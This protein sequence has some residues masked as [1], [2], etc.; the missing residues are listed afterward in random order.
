[1]TFSRRKFLASL[2][3][4]GLVIPGVYYAQREIR[5]RLINND[6]DVTAGEAVAEPASHQGDLLA[7]KLRGIWDFQL[8]D[9]GKLDAL[10]HD[11]L[12]MILDVGVTGRA[13]RGYLGTAISLRDKNEPE[14]RV[15]GS[16]ATLS[17]PRV[18][19]ILCDE[20]GPRYECDAVMDE[21]WD[22]WGNAG[23]GTLSGNLRDLGYSLQLPEQKK[24]FVA[25]KRLF[26][27]ARERKPLNAELLAWLSSVEHRLFHQIWH[28][29]RD[30]WHQ[31]SEKK[32]EALRGLGWQPGPIGRERDARGRAKHRNGSGEDFLFMH[33]G[34]MQRARELQPDLVCWSRLPLPA[35]FIEYDRQ[36]FI[37]YYENV[38]GCSVPPAWE[39]TEDEEYSQWLRSVKGSE[40][41]YSNYQVWESLYHDPEYLSQMTLGE[42][43]S[44][45]E[46]GI[47][48][49][50][51][52]RWAT[53]TRDPSNGM[54]LFWDRRYTDFSPRW[55]LPENDYLGDPFSSHVNPVF[56]M[57]H[58]WIDDRVE[59]WFRAHE[60][61]HPGEVERKTIKGVSWFAPG[62]WVQI[63]DPW[64]GA[65]SYGCIPSKNRRDRVALNKEEM[66][67]AL[68]IALSGETDVP[69][70]LRRI[71][72]RPWYA[73]NLKLE[74]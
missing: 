30:K 45:L 38:D 2:T 5:N 8:L 16:L 54:P 44:E 3:A 66:K 29:S 60:R 26:P 42:F 57:F 74:K 13:L 12:E 14:Y 43:G 11:K 47:H 73:R 62:R 21:I 58:G 72:R 59:D 15:L 69:D 22:S 52:M 51:H 39:P 17:A 20:H 27:E 50:L 1:M 25:H 53:V 18:R 36:G 9:N 56:W 31:L 64:L 55:F 70:L 67:L 71:A 6:K 61:I 68:R 4:A 33:R 46:L 40:A 65:S 41:F 7:E 10:P 32:R 34:M 48:D 35:P 23:A 37:R 49:W 28:A 24:R 19:W 63:A